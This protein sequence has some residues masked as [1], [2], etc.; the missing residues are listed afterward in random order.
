MIRIATAVAAL[1]LVLAGRDA[2]C[3]RAQ[4]EALVVRVYR[5]SDLVMPTPAHPYPGLWLPGSTPAAGWGGMSGAGGFGGGGIGGGGGGGFFDVPPEALGQFGGAGAAGGGGIA[6]GDAVGGGGFLEGAPAGSSRFTVQDL[7]HAI[8]AMV[9][10]ETWQ[11]AGGAGSI[12]ALGGNLV[13][14]Q[15][16][17]VHA[18]VLEFLTALRTEG[19]SLRSVTVQ[20]HWL[21]LD[22]EQL[23]QLAADEA[24]PARRVRPEALAELAAA[25]PGYHGEVT[26]IDDQVV[27]IISG[28]L[29]TLVRG[30]IPVVGSLAPTTSELRLVQLA[31]GETG[32]ATAT[33]RA[34]GYQP[35]VDRVH[36]GALLEVRPSLVAGTQRAVLDLRSY[37][38][39]WGAAEPE[40]V[41]PSGVIDRPQIVA[42]QI[43]TTIQATLGQPVIAGGLTLEAGEGDRPSAGQLYLIVQVDSAAE[44][45]E[46]ASAGP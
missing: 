43:A 16:P 30:A 37:V 34:V 9:S 27:H 44:M 1:I 24:G 45:G 5:I 2:P 18:R 6:A 7:I 35:V 10:P 42:H 31:E 36:T 46:D 13:V 33:G 26:C 17:P 38:T 28:R 39:G 41:V 20:A 21:L 4:E 25:V 19:G 40:A 12:I 3:A 14:N 23:R 22:H 32:L 8:T 11:D 29:R 15:V